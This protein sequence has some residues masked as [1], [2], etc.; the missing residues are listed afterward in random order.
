MEHYGTLWK[1]YEALQNVTEALC[2][3]TGR[4]GTLHS[5]A[6]RYG[7]LWKCYGVLRSIKEHY[8][9]L[10]DVTKHYGSIADRYGS[11]TELLRNRYG[12]H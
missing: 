3:V 11:I 5:V 1:R 4:Y 9:A 12:K 6:G 2:S 8:G 7:T 10:H